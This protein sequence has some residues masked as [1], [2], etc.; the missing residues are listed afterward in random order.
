[1]KKLF[2]IFAIL[3]GI[4]TTS[5]QEFDLGVK[6]GANFATIS[7]VD[8]LDNK[9]GLRAGLF[10]GL[11][12]DKIGIQPEILYSEQGGKNDFGDYELNYV[13]IPVMF[14]FY[15]IGDIV[16]FQ[17]GPQF[18]FVIE[19]SFP[20]MEGVDSQVNT[21]DFDFSGAAGI[22]VELPLGVRVEAR[23]NFGLTDVSDNGA[24]KNN[25]ISVALGYSFL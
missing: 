13:N 6:V 3:G 8:D 5:A 16:N 23:Y 21:N 12:Y 14:K 1:M 22:G 24:G 15:I 18:G 11:K 10:L 20:T 7:D 2:L 25:V 9:T 17:I 19:D 4:A